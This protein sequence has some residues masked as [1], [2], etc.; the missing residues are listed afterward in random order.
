MKKGMK[1]SPEVRQRMS[2]ARKKAW[3]DPAVRE[4]MSVASKK[5]LAD[6]AVR[7]RMS[8]ARKKAWADP[9]VRERMS[10]ARKKALADP[11]VR[12]KRKKKYAQRK[13]KVKIE[14]AKF[15]CAACREENCNA[16][17]GGSCRCVCSLELDVKRVRK[18]RAA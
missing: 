3:A 6:P 1:C 10:V 11:A 9:E 18:N 14:D 16:C 7:E 15:L 12:A 17:D 4:R 2:V 13:Y 5:A 8:V